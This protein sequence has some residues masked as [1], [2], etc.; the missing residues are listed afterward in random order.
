ME[1]AFQARRSSM[2]RGLGNAV[3]AIVV[4]SLIDKYCYDGRYTDAALAMLRH[5]QHSFGL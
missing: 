3:V 2:I 5:I 1:F 4:A